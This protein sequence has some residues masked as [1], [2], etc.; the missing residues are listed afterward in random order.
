MPSAPASPRAVSGG[1]AVRRCHAQRAAPAGRALKTPTPGTRR[2]RSSYAACGSARRGRRAL[3]RRAPHRLKARRR[4][5]AGGVG[6]GGLAPCRHRRCESTPALGSPSGAA[7]QE[8]SQ[9]HGQAAWQL[10]APGMLSF[11]HS[12]AS[13]DVCTQDLGEEVIRLPGSAATAHIPPRA[14][15]S[16]REQT[17][18]SALAA[19]LAAHPPPLRRLPTYRLAHYCG[20]PAPALRGCCMLHAHRE[21]PG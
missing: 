4:R 10:P 5:V 7:V 2:A 9:Q 20:T 14:L 12:Q 15:Q 8:G 11:Q 16:S 6:W 21:L 3:S 19:A 1:A 13:F 18:T 17:P